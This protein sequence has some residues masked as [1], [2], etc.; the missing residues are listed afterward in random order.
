MKKM[1]IGIVLGTLLVFCLGSEYGST[2]VEVSGQ[3]NTPVVRYQGTMSGVAPDGTCYF[4]VTDTQTGTSTL[5][6]VS[7]ATPFGP[8]A[9]LAGQS[10]RV[11]ARLGSN[12]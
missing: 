12:Y 7:D 4:A 10:G 6:K 2:R 3:L 5:F 9:L 11:V 1:V 8:G